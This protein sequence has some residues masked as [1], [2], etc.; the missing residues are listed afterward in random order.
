[1]KCLDAKSL[2]E[3]SL[4]A[5]WTDTSRVREFRA[6][7]FPTRMECLKEANRDLTWEIMQPS[8]PFS[9]GGPAISPLSSVKQSLTSSNLMAHWAISSLLQIKLIVIVNT[10][11]S[12]AKLAKRVFWNIPDIYRFFR[13]HRV[14]V[15]AQSWRWSEWR[16]SRRPVARVSFERK[17]IFIKTNEQIE[18]N[19]TFWKFSSP[20]HVAFGIA[21]Y[22]KTSL[23]SRFILLTAIF[24]IFT[25]N[26]SFL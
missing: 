26:L 19:V 21:D 2:S 22:L 1:M 10:S 17:F 5:D 25:T 11:K 7:M 16:N 23:N 14:H 15:N 6:K 18:K 8:P 3:T 20:R 24:A 9:P 4:W 13:S 12:F